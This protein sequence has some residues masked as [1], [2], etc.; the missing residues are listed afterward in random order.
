MQH[1]SAVFRQF[2]GQLAWRQSRFEGRLEPFSAW[3]NPYSFEFLSQ[4]CIQNKILED[5]FQTNVASGYLPDVPFIV[6][7]CWFYFVPG[8][9]INVVAVRMVVLWFVLWLWLWSV[10]G[11]FAVG[12][13]F[14][15]WWFCDRF[16]G[17]LWSVLWSVCGRDLWSFVLFILKPN[18]RYRWTLKQ[19]QT[20]LPYYACREHTCAYIYIYI[21]I[22]DVRSHVW[23][24]TQTLKI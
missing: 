5:G 10:C 11:R 21:Y 18:C 15:L 13:L 7:L 16:C 20:S 23:A 2:L 8:V 22:Y 17:G 9:G 1:Q 6:R 12:F 24:D 19:S 3:G 14:D 4:N